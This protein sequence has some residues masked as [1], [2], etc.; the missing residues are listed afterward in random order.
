MS[1][2]RAM[3]SDV[4][5]VA[6][7]VAA[8]VLTLPL[9]G[10]AG[11]AGL[12]PSHHHA[13]QSGSPAAEQSGSPAAILALV[14][15]ELGR[16][17]TATYRLSGQLA[18][19]PGHEWTVVVSHRGRPPRNDWLTSGGEWSFALRT[20]TGLS[21]QWIE[22]GNHHVTCWRRGRDPLSCGAS[23]TQP[24]NG[25]FEAVVAYV[26]VTIATSLAAA[27]Q[28]PG[29]RLDTSSRPSR[30]GILR[31]VEDR[32]TSWCFTP[33]GLPAW[34]RS[35]AAVGVGSFGAATVVLLSEHDRA[36]A[37]T[38]VPAG[39]PKGGGMPPV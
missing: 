34:V 33:A 28:A 30:F 12:A 25:T 22:D 13:E 39:R 3:L 29:G 6:V 27:T 37:S 32:A 4:N 16:R 14:R 15:A 11:F 2:A 31:C 19:Y 1:A 5:S 23:V 36:S 7:P 21:V 38:F 9:A 24:S 35:S 26:P 8:S 10:F 18:P 20:S 17:F